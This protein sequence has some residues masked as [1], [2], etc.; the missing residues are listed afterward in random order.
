MEVIVGL[1]QSIGSLLVRNLQMPVLLVHGIKKIF[2]I[3]YNYFT[4][5]QKKRHVRINSTMVVTEINKSFLRY[6]K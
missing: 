1:F 4:D 5:T 6:R 3:E 2:I